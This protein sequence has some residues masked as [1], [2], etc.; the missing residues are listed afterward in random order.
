[1]AVL[2]SPG[3]PLEAHANIK[4]N[5]STLLGLSWRR[6]L[7]SFWDLECHTDIGHLQLN[8][9]LTEGVLVSVINI[10]RVLDRRGYFNSVFVRRLTDARVNTSNDPVHLPQCLG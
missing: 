8:S 2:H 3:F 9:V 10:F 1:M 5:I 4:D 6:I 7:P